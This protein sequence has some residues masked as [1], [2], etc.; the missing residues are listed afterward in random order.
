M[1]A[2]KTK[3]QSGF[4]QSVA[5]YWLA[6]FTALIF[7]VFTIATPRFATASNIFNIIGSA[8]TMA[9]AAMGMTCVMAA[10]EIDFSAGAQVSMGGVLF[11]K[12]LMINGFDSVVIAAVITILALACVGLIN[13]F[14]HIVVKMPSF[15]ATMG[16]NYLILG[17]AKF[18]SNGGQVIMNAR[19]WPDS[20]TFIGQGRLFGLIPYTVF[21]LL[22][23][24]AF[25]YVY[26]QKTRWG[27]YLYAVG[28]NPHAC[29]YIGISRK[30]QKLRGF[31]LCSVL[32]AIAGV[33]MTSM[34]NSC[35]AL[36][37]DGTMLQ[38]I[39]CLMLGATFITMGVYNV[40][41][42]IIAALMLTALTYGLT[43][44]GAKEYV[45][46]LVEGVILIVSVS[47]VTVIRLKGGM[48]S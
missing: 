37:G 7:I 10:G 48:K 28:V 14:L 12:L 44:L 40:P 8:C 33:V 4:V 34:L 32:S 35:N 2:V 11:G 6:L 46:S 25:M 16:M 20:Y 29:D 31:V 42:T 24:S 45:K 3:K 39:T 30:Q 21:V 17:M 1:E 23:V 43:M 13:A 19:Q 26:T 22:I 5:K 38:S 18:L 47:V 36:M 41:G 9:I 27:K 15:I